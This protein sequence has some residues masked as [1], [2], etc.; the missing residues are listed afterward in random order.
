MLELSQNDFLARSLIKE[1]IKTTHICVN[2]SKSQQKPDNLCKT[3][4]V[5][6]YINNKY[7]SHCLIAI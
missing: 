3:K 5:R 1:V 2:V 4:L 6:F 7:L